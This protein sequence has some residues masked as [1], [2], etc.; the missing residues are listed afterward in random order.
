MN[1]LQA[2]VLVG[3][4]AGAAQPAAPP[5]S[6]SPSNVQVRVSGTLINAV[7]QQQVEQ[8]QLVDENILGVQYNGVSKTCTQ[9]NAELVSSPNHAILEL[10]GTGIANADNY[11]YRGKY[12][13]H[14]WT[15]MPFQIRKRI[16]VDSK[17]ICPYP[18]SASVTAHSD[19][20]GLANLRGEEYR[21]SLLFARATACSEREESDLIAADR[22]RERMASQFDDEVYS[23]LAR[24]HQ[25]LADALSVA[26]RLDLTPRPF[27]WSTTSDQVHLKITVPTPSQPAVSSLPPAPPKSAD[28]VIGFHESLIN[29]LAQKTLAGQT[30]TFDRLADVIG[31]LSPVL[32]G[33]D[34]LAGKMT[35]LKKLTRQI[36]TPG[37]DPLVMTFPQHRPLTVTFGDEGFTISS[38]GVRFKE[39]KITYPALDSRVS[40]RIEKTATGLAAVRKGPVE[41]LAPPGS[42][43]VPDLV[44][45]S[46]LALS[47][48]LLFLDRLNMTGIPLSGSSGTQSGLLVPVQA[49]AEQGW[50]QLSWVRRAK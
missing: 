21:L 15:M 39:G 37:A 8:L 36:H 13:V 11:G 44:L 9:I 5:E 43:T 1:A 45:L 10:I 47:F 22:A 46:R 20:L 25:T 41:V 35:T 29:E 14:S 34:E 42:G 17:L 32:L 16:A 12:Q 28:L 38:H 19:I 26:R 50:L 4:A 31:T 7:V 6:A 2:L 49:D 27:D 23:Y 33:N 3:L 40:Y 24:G 48:N 30:V 18:A